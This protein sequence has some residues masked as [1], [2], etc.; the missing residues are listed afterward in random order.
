MLVTLKGEAFVLYESRYRPLP[1]RD[2]DSFT[3]QVEDLL[4]GRGSIDIEVVLSRTASLGIRDL[5]SKGDEICA[6][7]IRRAFDADEIAYSPDEWVTKEILLTSENFPWESQVVSDVELRKYILHRAYWL[8]YKTSESPGTYWMDFGLGY[9]LEYLGVFRDSVVRVLW[10]LG[11]SGLLEYQSGTVARPT[12]KLVVE[13]EGASTDA[14]G[15][16]KVF[17]K[18]TEYDSYKA[19]AQVLRSGSLKLFVADNYVDESLLELLSGVARGVSIRILTWRTRSD[20]NLALQK[21]RKQYNLTVEVRK[22]SGD[23]H[24]RAVIVDGTRCF[25]LGASIK[26]AGT[27]LWS[28]QELKEQ[29]AISD[30]LEN[31]E[32]SWSAAVPI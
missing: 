15:Q 6:N 8:G 12:G 11:Q 16:A 17:G 19:I 3:T 26:D 10:L 30:L 25:L 2:A 7:A 29:R 13:Y 5:E 23:I 9:E 28:L 18:G 24:D 20:F 31:L 1:H 27:R 22:H 14:I 21:F 32:K 4:A